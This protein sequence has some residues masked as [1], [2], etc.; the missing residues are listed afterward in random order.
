M[1]QENQ[2]NI[3]VY[4]RQFTHNYQHQIDSESKEEVNC[5]NLPRFKQFVVSDDDY[6]SFYCSKCL[7]KGH[8]E[9]MPLKQ[10]STDD[11]M[12]ILSMRITRC[13]NFIAIIGGKNLIKEEEELHQ[14]LIYQINSKRN[15]TKI[16]DYELPEEFRSY[17]RAF[18]FCYRNDLPITEGKSLFLISANEIK[19]FDFSKDTPVIIPLLKLSSSLGSQPDYVVFNPGQE[20]CIIATKTDALWVRLESSLKT[21]INNEIDLDEKFD[22]SDIRCLAVFQENFYVLTNKMLKKQ[23]AY[24]LQ[25]PF[26]LSDQMMVDEQFQFVF[27]QR[28]DLLIDDGNIDFKIIGDEN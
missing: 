3:F 26:D 27:K 25:I 2:P 24:V 18:E 11:K 13:E 12:E 15:F 7:T 20:Y 10:S 16:V 9:F 17:S 1:F 22:F 19:A 6:I 5:V 4:F 14:I 21:D 28:I 8:K 23:G